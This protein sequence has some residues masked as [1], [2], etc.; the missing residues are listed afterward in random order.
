MKSPVHFPAERLQ[1]ILNSAVDTGIITLD[2][3]GNITSWSKGAES[4]L[5]WSQEE[6]LGKTLI[7]IFLVTRAPPNC[8]QLSSPMLA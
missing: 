5:G 6:M 3:E 8:W 7:E 4:L 2:A 1:Q